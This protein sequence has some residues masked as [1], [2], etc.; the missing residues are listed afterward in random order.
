MKFVRRPMAC[1]VLCAC[2]ALAHAAPAC[3]QAVSAQQAKAANLLVLEV[4]LD[5]QLLSDGL[6][7][8]Q[9]GNDVYLPLGDLARLLTI[10]I[11]TRPVDGSASGFILQEARTFS[12]NVIERQVA[13]AGR[14]EPL[15]RSQFKLQQDDIYVASRLLARWLP[16]DLDVDMSS[17]QLRVHARE[18]LPLQARLAR[19]ARPEASGGAETPDP[20]YPR[21]A[22]PYALA[23]V[24][25]IDQTVGLDLRNGRRPEPSYTAYLTGDLLGMQAALYANA[26]RG[27]GSAG[28][29]QDLR[30]TLGR[31][32]PDAGLLGPLHARSALVGSVQVPGV[33]GISLG[34]PTGNGASLGNRP[35]YL[36]ARFDRHN[37]QGDLPPGWDVELYFNEALVGFQAA[38]A[39]GKYVFEN[40]PL[41][42]GANEFRLVFHGPL[43]QVRVERQSFLLEQS[44][45]APGTLYYSVASHHDEFGR[46]RSAAQFDLGLPGGLTLS[47]GDTRLPLSGVGQRYTNVGLRQYLQSVIL[48]IDAASSSHGG[49][50]AHAELKTRIGG[51]SVS[52]GHAALRDFASEVYLPSS[53][54]IRSRD[55]LRVDGVLRGAPALVLPVSVSVQRDRLASNARNLQVEARVA[56][57]RNGTAVSNALRWQSLYDKRF[58]EGLLQLS[59]RLAGIGVTGQLQYALRPAH[60]V[61][62]L[63]LAADKYLAEGYMLNLGMLRAFQNPH[64]DFSAALNKSLGSFGLGLTA[65]YS[66]QHEYGAGIQLFMALGQEPRSAA[67]HADAQPLAPTGAAS[68]RVFVDKNLDGTMDPGDEPVRGA[69]FTVNGGSQLA[70]TDGAG[71]AYL[72]RLPADQHVDLA[73]DS[74]TLEDPQWIPRQPG[75]RLVPRPGKV[76]Q[77]DFPVIVTGEIDGTAWMVR[78]DGSRRPAGDLQL[79]LVDGGRKVV[80][81]VASSSDGYF[82]LSNVA[83]GDY[84]LRVSREQLRRLK[85]HD[86]GM[87]LVTVNR[88]GSF[89]NGRELYVEADGAPGT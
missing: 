84:L 89:V 41:V 15:D 9:Y 23:G 83:P 45:V 61:T 72:S 76:T 30:L 56:A 63:A 2:L 47:A 19:G 37:L 68:I 43:G 79:E 82:V 33:S 8:F 17:L 52:A 50:L 51:L 69:G 71:I 59:R 87:H 22:I 54:P 7:A 64:Y 49:A 74:A 10:A 35:L 70:R 81:Q 18:Q 77:L 48:G 58:A 78:P 65:H 60:S 26:G 57:Y 3:A 53:D 80:A 28:S 75:V 20:G 66:T 62:S 13:L 32:D 73:L 24:P 40:L 55:E 85:M 14:G 21:K 34:S 6:T 36:P 42:Y 16:V 12:L 67:W 4:S 1:A 44:L 29:G 39:S 86:L 5:Q 38:G 31:N 11:T 25:F 27:S 46:L 88:D